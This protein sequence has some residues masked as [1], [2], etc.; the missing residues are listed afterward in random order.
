[1]RPE[2]RLLWPPLG[3]W[4]SELGQAAVAAARRH[5]DKATL[6]HYCWMPPKKD[7][8]KPAGLKTATKPSSSTPKGGKVTAKDGRSKSPAKKPVKEAAPDPVD[9]AAAAAKDPVDEAA[10]AARAREE[11]AAAEAAAAAVAAEKLKTNGRVMVRYNHYDKSYEVVDGKLNWEDVDDEYAISF[12]FKGNWACHLSC[13]GETILPDGGGLHIE[14]RKDPDGF[15]P[16]ADEEKWCGFFSGLT[17]VDTGGKP[18]EYRLEVQEDAVWEAAQGP[19][20][21]YRAPE[22]DAGITK[23]R[24]ESCSCIEGNPCADAYCCKDWKNRFEVAT[25]NGWKGFS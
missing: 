16:D 12:V 23:Q 4:A 17:V 24:M 8:A 14:M 15:D 5:L 22:P 13:E 10:T 21:T 3:V 6:P 2:G 7:A 11:A 18:K 25:K 20:V 19:R 1:M 9:E